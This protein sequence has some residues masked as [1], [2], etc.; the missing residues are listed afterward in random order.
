M[1]CNSKI[2]AVILAAGASTRMGQ[3]KQLL[4]WKSTTLLNH[5]I[6]EVIQADIIE[7]AVILGSNHEEIQST[8][9]P[10]TIH[11][12]YNTN[13]ENGMGSSIAKATE[14]AMKKNIDGVL[15]VLA[16]QPFVDS[17]YLNILLNEYIPKQ[18]Q[19]IGTSYN[20][21]VGVPAI[22]DKRYFS[23]LISLTGKQGAK[24]LIHKY[25]PKVTKFS[26]DFDFQDIDTPEDYRQLRKLS[27]K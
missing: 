16:D 22:F 19:I 3:P 23:E 13:W 2:V 17:N 14:Y 9:K 4:P 1:I 7:T 8:I 11:C 25:A 15:F 20:N 21:H 6:N 10:S 26:P 27:C 18:N 12:I 24:D 5:C